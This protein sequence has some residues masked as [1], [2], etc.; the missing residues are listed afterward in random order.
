MRWDIIELLGFEMYGPAAAIAD[1]ENFYANVS[2]EQVE[3]FDADVAVLFPIGYTLEDLEGDPLLSS[4]SVV[5]DGR[6]VLLDDGEAL[7]Q[8]FSAGSPPAIEVVLDELTPQL[9]DA[10]ENL[11]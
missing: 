7:V 2:E 4:L 11:G 10:V 8:A 9:A 3:I 5:G 1:P 6:A